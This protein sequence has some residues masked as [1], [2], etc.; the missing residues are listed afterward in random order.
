MEMTTFNET[1]HRPTRRHEPRH[2]TEDYLA[3]VVTANPPGHF[4]ARIMDISGTGLRFRGSS[5]LEAGGSISIILEK[6]IVEGKIRYCVANEVGTLDVGV[7]IG[8]I[9]DRLVDPLET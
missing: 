3:Q 5:Q 8:L 7:K 2:R 4:E 9:H 1:S 6:L